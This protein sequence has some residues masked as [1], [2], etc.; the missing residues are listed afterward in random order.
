MNKYEMDRLR[1]RVAATREGG[2]VLRC[3]TVP[4]NGRYDVAQHSFGAVSLLLILH[5]NPSLDL[6]KAT[7]W[8][9]VAERWMGDMPAPA[10]WS[11]PVLGEAYAEV[12]DGI[13]KALDLL[14]D[15][16][17]EDHEW[18]KAVDTLDLWLWCRSEEA[19]GNRNVVQMRQA[20]EKVLGERRSAGVIPDVAWLF[21]I[22]TRGQ[23][24]E[25]LP[26]FFGEI[27][28]DGLGEAKTR[29]GE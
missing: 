4:H 29:L 11:N 17:D 8:H 10:K 19:M 27:I 23:T 18:L 7:Q 15:L 1:L 24:H 13:M 20:C 2:A 26:E 9:D 16:T 25:R 6:I 21:F 3:H 28:D 22:Q 14:P 5:P 12:E